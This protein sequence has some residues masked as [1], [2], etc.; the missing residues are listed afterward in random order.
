MQISI[1]EP[2]SF[3]DK[4]F[5]ENCWACNVFAYMTY[6]KNLSLNAWRGYSTNSRNSKVVSENTN[7]SLKRVFGTPCKVLFYSEISLIQFSFNFNFK[8]LI[9]VKMKPTPAWHISFL[10][11]NWLT[12][13]LNNGEIFFENNGT[14]INYRRQAF[15]SNFPFLNTHIPRQS[16]VGCMLNFSKKMV[17]SK[18]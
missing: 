4:Q 7:E 16:P 17:Y 8:V 1:L 10:Y 12:S 6:N 3:S 14:V 11:S 15:R 18:F 2:G 13:I 5:C 9:K